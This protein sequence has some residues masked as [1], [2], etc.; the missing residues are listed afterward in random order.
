M[1]LMKSQ[2]LADAVDAIFEAVL[3]KIAAS[4]VMTEEAG[5]VANGRVDVGGGGKLAHTHTCAHELTF[6]YPLVYKG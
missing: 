3:P 4:Q 1:T 6:A 5:V 2:L